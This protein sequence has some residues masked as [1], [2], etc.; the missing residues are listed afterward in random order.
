MLWLSQ[1][2][3]SCK[4]RAQTRDRQKTNTTENIVSFGR[5]TNGSGADAVTAPR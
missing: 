1:A 2:W 5:E 3:V 4:L